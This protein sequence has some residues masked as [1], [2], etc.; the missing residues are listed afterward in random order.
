MSKSARVVFKWFHRPL[1]SRQPAVINIYHT[2]ASRVWPCVICGGENGINGYQLAVFSV[3]IA[4]AHHFVATHPPP[5]YR[6]TFLV[7]LAAPVKILS[8]TVANSASYPLNSW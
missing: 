7:V 5:P 8:K 4:F 3:V 6:N 2:I 1:T